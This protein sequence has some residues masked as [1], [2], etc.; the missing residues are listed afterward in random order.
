MYF[1]HVEMMLTFKRVNSLHYFLKTAPGFYAELQS[2]K[3]N[4]Y[5]HEVD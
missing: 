3:N 2:M 1:M 4:H 5:H